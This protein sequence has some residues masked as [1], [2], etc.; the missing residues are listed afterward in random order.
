MCTLSTTGEK[1]LGGIGS[2][3]EQKKARGGKALKREG[4]CLGNHLVAGGQYPQEQLQDGIEKK[5]CVREGQGRGK[6]KRN[7][8][9]GGSGTWLVARNS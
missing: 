5:A 4:R 2:Q 7:A 9:W 3:K 1:L 6:G 8:C